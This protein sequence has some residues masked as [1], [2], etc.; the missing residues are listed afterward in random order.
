[1]SEPLKTAQFQR[2]DCTNR[3]ALIACEVLYRECCHLTATGRHTIDHFWLSQGLHDLGPERM[4]ARIQEQIDSLPGGVHDAV[5]LGFGLCNN[6]IAGLR[7]GE[8]PLVVPKAHDCITLFLG[9]R[10]RYRELFDGAPGTYYLTTGWL[11]RDDSVAEDDEGATIQDQL[12]LGMSWE[13]LCE[14]YGEENAAFV[15]ETMGDLTQNYSRLV[16]I[17][18]PFEQDSHFEDT[19]RA[20]AQ[21]KGWEFA[22]VPGDL[23]LLSNLLAGHWDEDFVVAQP[24]ETLAPSYDEH[25]VCPCSCGN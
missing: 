9:S 17:R 22:S 25:V 14:K 12:G 20:G 15:A 4:S 8:V 23:R 16:Y 10:C 5:L 7:A 1:M 13:E 11:E 3:Y 6:G 19:A 21:A 24:G 2:P 18:M